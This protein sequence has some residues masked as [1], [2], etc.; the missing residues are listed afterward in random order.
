MNSYDLIMDLVGKVSDISDL[1]AVGAYNIRADGC[2]TARQNSENIEI[3]TKTDKPGIDIMVKP[4]PR[5]KPYTFRQSSPMAVWTI[6]STT[7]SISGKTPMS[8]L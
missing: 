4:A 6:W 7:T 2:G 8:P 5:V 3:I 1:P